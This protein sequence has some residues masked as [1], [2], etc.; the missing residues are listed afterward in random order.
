MSSDQLALSPQYI[1]FAE[2]VIFYIVTKVGDFNGRDEYYRNWKSEDLSGLVEE[3]TAEIS[4]KLE[5]DDFIEMYWR[6]MDLTLEGDGDGELYDIYCDSYDHI[7]G[8][9]PALSQRDI[10]DLD[11]PIDH[12]SPM[13][14]ELSPNATSESKIK[15]AE[16]IIFYIVTKIIDFT[17][18]DLDHSFL[19]WQS[20]DLKGLVEEIAMHTQTYVENDDS[21]KMYL[22]S[23]E[24]ENEEMVGDIHYEFYVDVL[25]DIPALALRNSNEIP[26]IMGDF[27]PM[28]LELFEHNQYEFQAEAHI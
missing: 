15:F 16:H 25:G 8:N 7:L 5:D 14:I 2:H 13:I 24:L 18:G 23:L 20:N 21:I 17:G 1:K 4:C 26:R 22:E 12:F 11:E 9:I 10:N 6:L 3:I 28:L 19:N 27:I